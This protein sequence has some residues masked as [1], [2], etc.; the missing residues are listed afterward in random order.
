VPPELA[1]TLFRPTE[2]L[3]D[4]LTAE[5]KLEAQQALEEKQVP[6]DRVKLK[7]IMAQ[8]QSLR[9]KIAILENGDNTEGKLKADTKFD[10]LGFGAVM[11]EML[12]G[13]SLLFRT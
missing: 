7:E 12:C 4:L 5:T 6:K 8:L 11:Y 13:R 9:D 10:V 3:A 2:T 1:A